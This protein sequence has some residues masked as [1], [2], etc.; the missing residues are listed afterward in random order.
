MVEIASKTTTPKLIMI[1]LL[2]IMLQSNYDLIR[3]ANNIIKILT[4][5]LNKIHELYL[6]LYVDNI[7][8]FNLAWEMGFNPIAQVI[9]QRLIAG[10][11][12]YS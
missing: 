3:K 6:I 11:S 1:E 4:I 10:I 2:N 9:S 8:L 7:Y 12:Y 5:N